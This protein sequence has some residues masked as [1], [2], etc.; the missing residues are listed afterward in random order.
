MLV[1]GPL[2]CQNRTAPFRAR[3][4]GNARPRAEAR[5]SDPAVWPH[6][7]PSML[8]GSLRR[9]Y[10][11]SGCCPFTIDSEQQVP[12]VASVEGSQQT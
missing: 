9:R 11:N 10:G 12:V 8:I 5:G 3:T 6:S 2:I 1:N 7:G 4:R